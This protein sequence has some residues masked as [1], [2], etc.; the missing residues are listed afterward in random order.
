M[1]KAFLK[2]LIMALARHLAT[3]AGGAL[4]TYGLIAAS[5]T[6]AVSGAIL[7]LIGVGLSAWDKVDQAKKA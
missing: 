1:S 3:T 4:A 5:Q 2:P 7:T 6:E